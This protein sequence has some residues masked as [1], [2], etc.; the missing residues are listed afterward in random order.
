MRR[1]LVFVLIFVIGAALAQRPFVG[2]STSGVLILSNQPT[3]FEMNLT[4][5][6]KE[7]RGPIDVRGSLLFGLRGGNQGGVDFGITA[8]GFYSFGAGE[9]S[10]YAGL[11]IG[12]N[13]LGS[14]LPDFHLLL[15]GEYMV[16]PRFG[17]YAELMPALL[18]GF[19]VTDYFV[20]FRVGTNIYF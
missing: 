10:P 12:F 5:G 18:F 8:E 17:L 20:Q 11:G 14:G 7:F 16:H 2:G 3:R 19:G 6:A 1:L 9:V 15:G 4:L 13:Q